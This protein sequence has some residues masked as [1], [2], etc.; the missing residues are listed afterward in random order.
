MPCLL[1]KLSAMPCHAVLCCAVLCCAVVLSSADEDDM[2]TDPDL[3]KHLA[4]WG[5]N[6]MQVGTGLRRVLLDC[7]Q[8]WGCCCLQLV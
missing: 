3:N 7:C 6:M 1:L 4:H 5:I 8:T 2:V